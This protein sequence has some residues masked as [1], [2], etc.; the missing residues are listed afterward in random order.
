[1]SAKCVSRGI[2]A[3]CFDAAG[4]ANPLCMGRQSDTPYVDV[5]CGMLDERENVGDHFGFLP[6]GDRSR[7]FCGVQ[8]ETGSLG[9]GS[10][11]GQRSA[12]P[13]KSS[14]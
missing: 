9:V 14:I 13:A 7:G 6:I 2:G 11:P 4:S 1:M 10:T 8:A 5:T 12:G 3:P